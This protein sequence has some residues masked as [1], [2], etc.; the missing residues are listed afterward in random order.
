MS[1]WQPMLV[2][3]LLGAVLAMTVGSGEAAKKVYA[4]F[5]TSMGEFTI[6]L[7]AD[8]TPITVKNFVE[9]AT[10]KKQWTDPRTGEKV[11]KRYYDGLIFHRVIDG[12]M[13]QGGCPLGTGTGGPGY[14]IPDEFD[15]SLRHNGPGILSMANTGQPN[16]GGAQFFIT[17][18]ATPHLDNRHTVFG[19]V[20]KG[21]DVVYAIAKVDTDG[22]DRPL[23]PVVIKKVTIQDHL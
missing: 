9:L 17:V 19:K 3:L 6:E 21:M 16:S 2:L 7:F 10:G 15:P 22:R 13:I 11:T 20:V 5:D 23:T 18:R 8:K 4:V 1:Y 12:F 14:N